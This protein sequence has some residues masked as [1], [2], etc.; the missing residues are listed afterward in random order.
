MSK[1]SDV[2]ISDVV[3][4]L[5]G[6]SGS[7]LIPETIGELFNKDETTSLTLVVVVRGIE[8]A[9]VIVNCGKCPIALEEIPP[10]ELEALLSVDVDM[11]C[12]VVFGVGGGSWAALGG[13]S[14]K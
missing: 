7:V 6:V 4:K 8:D 11:L 14:E 5:T 10:M 9:C 1:I 12:A 13:N 2:Q 3:V